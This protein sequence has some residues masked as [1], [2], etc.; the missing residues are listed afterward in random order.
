MKAYERLAELSA[1]L[2]EIGGL[3]VSASC[4]ARVAM[5]DFLRAVHAGAAHA[6]YELDEERRTEHALDHPIGF[7]EGGYLKALYSHPRRSRALS[8]PIA[9]PAA[10]PT[11]APRAPRPTPAET[12]RAPSA[13]RPRPPRPPRSDKPRPTG[14]PR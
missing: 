11:P 12:P 2:V 4:S 14:R 6:G 9:G 1:P 8:V 10:A 3:L 7:A 13:D 5:P